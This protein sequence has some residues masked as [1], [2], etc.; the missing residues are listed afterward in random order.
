LGDRAAAG[1]AAGRDHNSGADAMS[2]FG[3]KDIPWIV[4]AGIALMIIIMIIAGYYA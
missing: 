2:P 3:R 4:A 1:L